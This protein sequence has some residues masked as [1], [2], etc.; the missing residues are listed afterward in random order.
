MDVNTAFWY[1]MG[2]IFLL[3][4]LHLLAKPI[5]V[6]MRMVG[7]SLVGGLALWLINLVGGLVGFH[8]GLNP[9]SAAVVGVLGFPGLLGLSLLRVILG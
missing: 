5:E 8:L 7:S 9:I 3:L 6:A 4:L 1:A 2:V